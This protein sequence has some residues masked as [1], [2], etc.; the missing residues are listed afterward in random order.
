MSQVVLNG[1]IAGSVYALIALGFT[2]VYSTTRFFHFAHGGVYAAAAYVMF[3]LYGRMRLPLGPA[4]LG[5][6]G[7]AIAL[8]I[9]MEL[10]VYRPLRHRNSSSLELLV[11]SLGLLIV[12]Q[13]AISLL[14]GDDTKMLWSGNVVEG[15]SILG[16]RLTSVQILTFFITIILFAVTSIFVSKSQL[17]KSMRAVANDPELAV[18]C[19]LDTNRVIL[20]AFAIGSGLAGVGAI[21]V[22]FDVG[23]TPTMGLN[24]L[25]LGVVAVIV[26]GINSVPGAFLGG[27]L[28]GMAQHFAA[29]KIGSEWQDTIAF[30]ILIILLVVR[31]Q[32]FLGKPLRRMAV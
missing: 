4:L 2:L 31:P 25:M 20:A 21:L 29:R 26:G 24:A 8:G 13:N 32:G 11:A 28:L 23:L 16:A 14:F 12:L 7:I 5:T 27:L 17:G 30:L 22:A 15:T 3:V 10:L 1:V 18:I 9:G 19:G 6:I